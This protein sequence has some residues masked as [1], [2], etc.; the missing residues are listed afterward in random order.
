MVLNAEDRRLGP[1]GRRVAQELGLVYVDAEIAKEQTG[2]FLRFYID[3]DGGMTLDDCERFH[4]AIHPLVDDVEYDY[5]EVSSPGANRPLQTR[6][7]F[8]RGRGMKVTVKLY[9]ALDGQKV[10]SGVLEGLEDDVIKLEDGREFT[11]KSVSSVVPELDLEME[12]ENGP[13]VEIDG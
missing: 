7:D 11:L 10:F 4:R 8:E 13:V 9:R 6:F 5:L 2:R 12:L 1:V 3:K